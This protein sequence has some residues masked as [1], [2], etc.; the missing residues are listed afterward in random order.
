MAVIPLHPSLPVD[1]GPYLEDLFAQLR[2]LPP[3]EQEALIA[4]HCAEDAQLAGELRAMLMASS[5]ASDG[6]MQPGMRLDRYALV[7]CLGRGATASVWQAQDTRLERPVALKVFHPG[8]RTSEM[9]RVLLEARAVSDVV[10]DHV[11]RVHDVGASDD[12]SFFIDME[13]CAE[14]TPGRSERQVGLPMSQTAPASLS[15]AVRWVM[16]VARGAHAAHA[17]GI[18]HRDLKPDNILIRPVSRRAQVTDFGLAVPRLNP[19]QGLD[20]LG[21]RTITIHI[22]D[23]EHRSI[24]GTP[25]FMAPE[26]AAGLPDLDE[27]RDRAVL[28]GVDVYGLGVTLYTLLTGCAPYRPA[29][30]SPDPVADVL[31]QVR[32]G[33]P[34]ALRARPVRFPVPARL[35]RIVARA[36]DRDPTRRYA[37]AGALADDLARFLSNE[38]SSQDTRRPLLRMALAMRR[39]WRT[40][41][42]AA[43]VLMMVLSILISAHAVEQAQQAL[44]AAEAQTAAASSAA[45]QAEEDAENARIAANLARREARQAR[46]DQQAADRARQLSEAQADAAVLQAMTTLTESEALLLETEAE[47]VNTIA[48]QQAL[49]DAL[50]DTQARLTTESTSHQLTADAL[51]TTTADYETLQSA[52][53][54]AVQELTVLEARLEQERDAREAAEVSLARE[55]ALRASIE[56]L[57]TRPAPE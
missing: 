23:A 48:A 21:D 50:A 17:Q 27:E 34:P 2:D 43:A 5:V 7:R 4:R 19:E 6:E 38:P 20:A 51:L 33:P 3:A 31:A 49:A 40:V 22:E 39:H 32:A 44:A 46:A 28:I 54:A 56:E 13:L 36:M 24:A 26:A 37:D 18:F 41:S 57:L 29:L 11:I 47:L 8:R 42:A 55:Q 45:T 14:Y 15:E 53:D 1:E 35:E 12:G 52:Y 16:E 9:Q 10:S 30:G 25:I